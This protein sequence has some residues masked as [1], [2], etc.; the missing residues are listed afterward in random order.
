SRYVEYFTNQEIY[1]HYNSTSPIDGF[2]DY[3]EFTS[4][5]CNRNNSDYFD[6]DGIG[7][8][9]ITMP[10][11]VAYH[12]SLP[13]YDQKVI[14]R[15]FEDISSLPSFDNIV[16]FGLLDKYASSWKLTAI[17]GADYIDNAPFNVVDRNDDGYWIRINYQKW[18]GNIF[19]AYPFYNYYIDET[20][21]NVPS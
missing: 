6:P 10:R 7:A 5:T 4:G 1:D 9:R 21:S 15:E 2:L 13:I 20:Y 8:F 11:G 3:A 19:R 14:N 16:D 12:Y 18:A 17:T